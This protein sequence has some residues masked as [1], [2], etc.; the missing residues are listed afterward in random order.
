MKVSDK[1]DGY[2]EEGYHYY[3]EFRGE[4]LTVR[5]YSRRVMLETTVSYDADA[6]ERGERVVI[7]LADNTLSRNL[8]G[9]SF[10]RIK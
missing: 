2:W 1:I 8:R 5:D 7:A 6:A 10:T 4:A 9:E 3:I